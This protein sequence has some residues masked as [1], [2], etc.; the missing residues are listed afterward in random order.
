[1]GTG[2]EAIKTK[3]YLDIIAT[4]M[5]NLDADELKD[6]FIYLN[7]I[8]DGDFNRTIADSARAHLTEL[9][10]LYNRL[11][12]SVENYKDNLSTSLMDD[13]GKKGLLQLKKNHENNA[14]RLL[15]RNDAISDRVRIGNG[16]L[17]IRSGSIYQKAQTKIGRA[18]FYA[19]QKWVGNYSISTYSF[20]VMIIILMSVMLYLALYFNWLRKVIE[21]L[22][23]LKTRLK[24]E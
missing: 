18:H 2:L 15:L 20:N 7:S 19:P 8:H 5:G 3:N 6:G 16:R 12:S 1:M 4:E 24:K 21:T 22:G 11:Y 23:S 14:L 9:S 13:R 17:Q 10:L